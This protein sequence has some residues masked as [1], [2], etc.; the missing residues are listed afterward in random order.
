MLNL[1]GEGWLEDVS[2]AMIMSN[3]Q[4]SW[5]CCLVQFGREP[6]R[7]VGKLSGIMHRFGME[8]NPVMGTPGVERN[9]ARLKSWA[10]QA[11]ILEGWLP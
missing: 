5:L 8:R 4:S 3:S 6:L 2:Y 11:G 9:P 1:H 10:P 7:Q